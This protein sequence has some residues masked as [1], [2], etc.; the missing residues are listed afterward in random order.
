MTCVVDRATYEQHGIFYGPVT[1]VLLYVCL[2]VTRRYR[3][4]MAEPIELVFGR[5]AS[6]S[7]VVL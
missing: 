7:H 2:S 6:L 4:E 3:F 1:G 5:D